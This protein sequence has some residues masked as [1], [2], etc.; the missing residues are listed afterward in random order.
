MKRII[1]KSM[2]LMALLVFLAGCGNV[3]V[4][5]KEEL[6]VEFGKAIST[7][8][9][10]YLNTE[11]MSEEDVNTVIS[12]GQ[13]VIE[14]DELV[15]SQDYQKVGSYTVKISYDNN[16]YDVV[17]NVQDTVAPQFVEFKSDLE[18]YTNEKID[19][20]KIYKAEDLSEVTISVD[21][22]K[23]DYSTAGTY[24]AVVTAKDIYDNEET[25]EVSI[26]VKEKPAPKPSKPTSSSNKSNTSSNSSS[27]KSNSSA[28]SSSSSSS[29]NQSTD[30]KPQGG[31]V[32]ISATGSKYHSIPNCGRMNPNKASQVS[33]SEAK[34]RGFDA[35]KKCF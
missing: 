8:I 18:T 25:K 14:S 9:K 12:E 35:C 2:Y 34:R 33:V 23:V 19:F 15:E 5:T 27:N 32:W 29:S 22:S 6:N 13:L 28:S 11:E 21:D 16:E 3:E 7:N 26:S 30:R 17:V 10:D 4:L 31:K 24:N 20:S 1:K